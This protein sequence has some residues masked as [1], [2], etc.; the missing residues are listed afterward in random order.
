MAT[1][2]IGAAAVAAGPA[3]DDTR[4]STESETEEYSGKHPRQIRLPWVLTL[5][6]QNGGAEER[7]DGA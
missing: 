6:R 1:E 4:I 7:A 5:A 2:G 3:A